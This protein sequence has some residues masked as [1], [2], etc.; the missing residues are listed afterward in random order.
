MVEPASGGAALGMP[1]VEQRLS[2]VESRRW[3]GRALGLQR[4]GE[5]ELLLELLR[6]FRN[7][8]LA[9][10]ELNA[11]LVPLLPD[12]P[13]Q[14]LHPKFVPAE[15]LADPPSWS[16]ERSGVNEMAL[17]AAHPCINR[18]DELLASGL[19]LRILMGEEPLYLDLP[20]VAIQAYASQL[21]HV[22]RRR[23]RDQQLSA[24]THLAS[25]GWEK[26]RAGY[27]FCK[28][29]DR[30]LP[31]IPDPP[32]PQPIAG[33]RQLLVVIDADQQTACRQAAKGGWALAIGVPIAQL[34]QLHEA[35]SELP[36]TT[37]L[38]FCH[39]SDSLDSA[40][41][42]RMAAAIA[43]MPL[44]ALITSDETH[45]W[46][47]DS[48]IPAANRQCR[49]AVTPFRLICRGAIGG[50]V[51]ISAQSLRSLEIPDTCL[52][53]HALL[54]DIALQLAGRGA[55]FGHCNQAL[56]ARNLALNPTIP[57]VACP[58]DQH[59][60]TREQSAEVFSIT[61][62][63]AHSLLRAGGCIEQHPGLP[64]C[65]RF[66]F[67]PSE[68][69]LISILIPFRDK[70]WLTKACVDSVRRCAGSVSYEIILIDNG[71]EE[72]QTLA[73]LEEQKAWPDVRIVRV[74]QP[75]N[76]SRV[77]NIARQECRG[78][79]LLFLNND[80]EFQGVNVLSHLMDPFAFKNTWAVG[81]RLHY[82]EG[83][84]QHQGVVLIKGERRA[85][86]EPGKMV[87]E[88][89]VVKMIAPLC[90]QEEFSAATGA[91]LLVDAE[92]FD[93]VGGFNE[94]FAVTFNDV[95][96][97][98]RLREAGGS[99]VVTP[100]PYL[101][102]RESVSRGKDL[103]GA[104]L[105]RQQ[106]EQG[107]LRQRHRQLFGIGDPL[108]SDLLHPHS[109]QFE[110]RRRST[111]PLLPVPDGL[112]Y[113][114]RRAG[115]RCSPK[116]PLLLFAQFSADGDLRSDI[117]PLLKAYRN[118]ADIVFIGA[119]PGLLKKSRALRLLQGVCD[120]VLLRRN[121]GYDFGSWMTALRFCKQDLT[122]C[123][124]LILTNDSFWGPVRPLDSLFERLA[125][126]QADV[127]GLTD[128]LL[129][130]PHLQSAFVSYRPPVLSSESFNRFWDDLPLFPAKRALVKHCEV[131]LPVLLREDG[132]SL[133]SLYT[134]NASGNVL[135]FEWRELI[136]GQG[137]PF[138]K[139]SLLRD[140]P[141]HQDVSSWGS[142]VSLCN[143]WLARQI[144][145]Q[146]YPD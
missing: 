75:F 1:F 79:Y 120:V 39:A 32:A 86:L 73:W 25:C 58:R 16:P 97:C 23:C 81:S 57:D 125:S 110:L 26:F 135:H 72:P 9:G 49:V 104:A 144:S 45:Q 130:E 20:P 37:Q 15:L 60:M 134:T 119:T 106:R 142:V 103:A 65:H 43:A 87:S 92:K 4:K 93:R 47:A 53:L 127:V 24:F 99:V 6:H 105:V 12:W 88:S 112:I 83:A 69:V 11:A 137:F 44:A 7:L 54:I 41:A 8:G 19:L 38:S 13:P 42:N 48:S 74:S 59:L 98:L 21:R 61:K 46:S 143:P 56:I 18:V 114:W 100:E 67:V 126:S 85:V 90:L 115:F 107:L 138:L 129:Y 40:A 109:S 128:N 123:R 63:R 28:G 94:Q 118:Y 111:G 70:V 36:A 66:R 122:G 14:L 2:P 78:G 51:T 5:P 22:E 146:V 145:V 17:L 102:H 52:S 124:E 50:L 68:P 62:K 101:I 3:L 117:L 77:N 31:P 35:I 136:E 29:L 10:V 64:G 132:F 141:T 80:V 82:P 33:P 133:S 116:R 139:V 121:A 34:G 89:A 27:A 95:D 108:V 113:S 140:N 84:I 30:Y 131:G 91:C 55:G 71:S 96:L 76:F